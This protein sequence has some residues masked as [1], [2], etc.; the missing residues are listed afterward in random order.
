MAILITGGAGFIGSHLVD[1]LIE[2]GREVIVLDNFDD[3]YDPGLKRKNVESHLGCDNFKL[4]EGNIL[5]RALLEKL[6]REGNISKVVHLAARAGVR[7]SIE[8]PYLYEQVNVG[9]TLN[10][11][12]FSVENHIEQFV[13]GSSSSVYGLGAEVP[14]KEDRTSG[15]PISPYAVS[16]QSAEHFCHTWSRLYQLPVTVLRFFTVYG[17]RQRPEMAIH[18]FTRLIDRGV[19]IPVFGDGCSRRD[20]TYI[21]DIIEG[22][23]SAMEKSFPYEVFNLGESRTIELTELIRLIEKNLG[24]RAKIKRLSDQLGDVPITYADITRAER[25]IGYQPKVDIEEGIEKFVEWF[26]GGSR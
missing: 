8:D 14:F 9:G 15:T 11:L 20:Y 16:K 3:Y 5:D 12:Q 26:R 4:V 25:L 7:A 19:E 23:L 2:L 10:L 17:P 1:R 21:S 6:S 18:K 13:F 24:K 22:I